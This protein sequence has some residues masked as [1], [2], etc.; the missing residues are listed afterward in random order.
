M[1]LQ[2]SH[3]PEDYPPLKTDGISFH[4]VIDL[5]EDYEVY[6]FTKGY[7]PHRELATPYGVGRYDERRPGMYEGEQ[8]MADR[9]DVHCDAP[10]G[11]PRE[12]HDD[13][14]PGEVEHITVRALGH[15]GEHV[16]SWWQGVGSSAVI[17]K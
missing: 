3:R 17:E 13:R 2:V 5:G 16:L 8:F 6:D 11:V 7:D 1:T 4:T 10:R 9:R 14:G 15:L 12:P